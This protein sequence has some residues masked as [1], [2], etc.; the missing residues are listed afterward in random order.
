MSKTK[1]SKREGRFG[2]ERYRHQNKHGVIHN[3]NYALMCFQVL[4]DPRFFSFFISFKLNLEERHEDLN[5]HRVT[6]TSFWETPL[7]VNEAQ[8]PCTN[9]K[10]KSGFRI[11]CSVRT[12]LFEESTTTAL[13]PNLLGFSTFLGFRKAGGN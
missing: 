3:A 4:S 13:T 11:S 9:I 1:K 5:A 8:I 10:V 12:K 2:D 6:K 7:F